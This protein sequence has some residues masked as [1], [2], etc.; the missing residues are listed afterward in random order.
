MFWRTNCFIDLVNYSYRWILAFTIKVSFVKL[1]NP[2]KIGAMPDVTS[3]P[4]ILL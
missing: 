2:M 3:K 1:K 4:D